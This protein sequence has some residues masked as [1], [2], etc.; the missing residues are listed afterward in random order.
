VS[1]GFAKIV[2]I[3]KQ[4]I[5]GVMETII[6]QPKSLPKKSPYGDGNAADNIVEIIEEELAV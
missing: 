1:A 2:D 4:R 5:L 6:D 3:E